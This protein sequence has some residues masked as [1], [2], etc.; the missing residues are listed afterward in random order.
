MPI[1]TFVPMGQLIEVSDAFRAD[2]SP[3][4]ASKFPMKL[5]G[6]RTRR[7]NDSTNKKLQTAAWR[8][9]PRGLSVFN[10]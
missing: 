5:T 7:C 3:A 2:V 6:G 1:E 9:V 10:S 8:R 4:N